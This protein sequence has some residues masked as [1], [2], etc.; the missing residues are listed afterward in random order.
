MLEPCGPISLPKGPGRV[1]GVLDVWRGSDGLA[2]APD[3]LACPDCAAQAVR[4]I[5]APRLNHGTNGYGRAIE[6]AAASAD[7]PQVVKGAIPGM[8]GRPTQLTR[9]PLHAK[10]PRP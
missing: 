2:T 4:R 3:R 10:L 9:N 7:R 5:S 1:D 6:R 8:A